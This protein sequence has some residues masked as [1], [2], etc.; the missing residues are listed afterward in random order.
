M[1]DNIAVMDRRTGHWQGA[2]FKAEMQV[3][4]IIYLC[5][6]N[7]AG[8]KVL[9]KIDSEPEKYKSKSN[10]LQRKYEVLFQ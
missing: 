5:H 3:G 2:A 6:G 7:D 4:D 9:G 8:I 1:A 10:W